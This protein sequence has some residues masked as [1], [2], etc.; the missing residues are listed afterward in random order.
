MLLGVSGLE[1]RAGALAPTGHLPSSFL[2][3]GASA[4]ETTL[5]LARRRVRRLDLRSNRWRAPACSRMT[6]PVPVTRKRFLAPECV[7][8]F[9][10]CV[11]SFVSPACGCGRGG[12]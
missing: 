3:L 6:L 2:I 7:L 11:L 9:G 1:C 4:G 5:S 12:S 8:F 10:T